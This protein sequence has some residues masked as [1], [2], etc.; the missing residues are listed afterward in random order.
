MCLSASY[1][2]TFAV[3]PDRVPVITK[4]LNRLAL[5]VLMSILKYELE[6]TKPFS[7]KWLPWSVM[8]IE[9]TPPISSEYANSFAPVPEDTLC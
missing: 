3:L 2:T 8:F 1:E 4:S 7:L 9:P 5:G 6:E